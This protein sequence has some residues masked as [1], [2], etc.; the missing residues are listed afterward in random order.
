M[1]LPLATKSRV[2]V[3]S[4]P[5]LSGGP[6][7]LGRGEGNQGLS[8]WNLSRTIAPGNYD[9]LPAKVGIFPTF[10]AAVI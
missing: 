4:T 6:S 2:S 3:P 5:F 10:F 9:A 1:S 8:A 7:A